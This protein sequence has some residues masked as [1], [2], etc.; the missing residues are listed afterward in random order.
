MTPG[1]EAA[2]GPS[3]D[4][5]A[6]TQRDD[7]LSPL[8]RALIGLLSG[9][10]QVAAQRYPAERNKELARQLATGNGY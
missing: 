10:G 9:G 2:I 5:Y 3:I 8:N 1:H 4:R 6:R 7:Y